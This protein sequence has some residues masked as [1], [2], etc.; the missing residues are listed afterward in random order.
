MT[1]YPNFSKRYLAGFAGLIFATALTAQTQKTWQATTG[2]IRE[3]DYY[4]IEVPA[5][6]VGISK[7]DNFPDL[8]VYDTTGKETPYFVRSQNPVEEVE[9]FVSYSLSANEGKDSI[10]RVVVDNLREEMIDRFY[11]IVKQAEVRKKISVRGSND[12]QQ[13]LMVKESHSQNYSGY[14]KDANELIPVDFP[15]GNYRYYELMMVNSGHSPLEVLNVVRMEHDRIYTLP[16]EVYSGPAATGGEP[17]EQTFTL[18]ELQSFYRV[19]KI[20][21][22]VRSR[23]DYYRKG[24]IYPGSMPFTLHSFSG[25]EVYLNSGVIGPQ[26][27]FTIDNHDNPPLQI[28]SVTLYSLKR[29]ICAFLEEGQSYTL[30]IPTDYTGSRPGY[31]IEHFRHKIPDNLQVLSCGPVE[32]KSVTAYK[33]DRSVSWIERPVVLWSIIIL[34]GLFLSFL[35]WRMLRELK[36]R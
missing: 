29:Y 19:D 11:L 21:F 15:K 23:A 8:R 33:E 17:A 28:D 16:G 18:P 31:D 27:V 2:V 5:E 36:K 10:N 4:H 3:S 25:G 14:R 35:C 1:V 22:S 30:S 20:K 6:L 7:A 13:W 32:I 26:T 24:T 12:K 34:T 9:R